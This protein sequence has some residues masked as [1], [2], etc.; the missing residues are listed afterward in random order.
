MEDGEGA[1]G[2]IAAHQLAVGVEGHARNLQLDVI[3]VGPEPRHFGRRGRAADDGAGRLLGLLQGVGHALQPVHDAAV[4][5]DRP[6]RH[7]ADGVDVRVA[8][9]GGLIDH[10]A[11]FARQSRRARQSLAGEGADADQHRVRRGRDP[12]IAV[13]GEGR[14]QALEKEARDAADAIQEQRLSEMRTYAADFNGIQQ[15][16]I[17]GVSMPQAGRRA[18][19]SARETS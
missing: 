16:P 15:E 11:V 12:W 17:E 10:Y 2:R 14:L 18:P 3:L 6:P 9:A 5:R 8:G 19:S 7:I 1:A 13:V 4:D